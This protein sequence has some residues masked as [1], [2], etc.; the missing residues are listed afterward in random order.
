MGVSD[1]GYIAQVMYGV[2][3]YRIGMHYHYE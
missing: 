2:D 1:I 3:S